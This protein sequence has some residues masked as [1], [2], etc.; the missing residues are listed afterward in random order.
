VG[1]V[2]KDV[3]A[4][5]ELE[6]IRLQMVDGQLAATLQISNHSKGTLHSISDDNRPLHFSWRMPPAQATFGPEDGW[7]TRKAFNADVGPSEQRSVQI[8]IEPPKAPGIYRL[9]ASVVQEYV[10][11]FHQDGMPI[12]HSAE[13]IEVKTDGTVTLVHPASTP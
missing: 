7:N 10:V 9:E 2:P 5:T 13:N 4:A 6:V 12:A 3:I 1:D 8:L 11:W